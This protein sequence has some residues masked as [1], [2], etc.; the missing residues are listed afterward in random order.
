MP[1]VSVSRVWRP[2]KHSK[3]SIS[4]MNEQW[5][6]IA[7]ILAALYGII[8]APFLWMVLLAQ[9][10]CQI[11]RKPKDL[12]V[13]CQ[14]FED[15]STVF[16]KDEFIKELKRLSVYCGVSV[17]SEKLNNCQKVSEEDVILLFKDVMKLC[18][19]LI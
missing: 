10:V 5:C 7:D 2:R 14:Y 1:R 3:Y 17:L 16:S 18:E 4:R 11:R 19:T 6:K 15:L 12:E 8:F 13:C 9:A